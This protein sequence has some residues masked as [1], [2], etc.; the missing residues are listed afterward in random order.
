MRNEAPHCL[1]W[2]AHHQSIGIEH[3]IVYSNDCDDG[4]TEILDRLQSIGL[5]SHIPQPA[6]KGRKSIQWQALK[7]AQSHPKLA[8]ADWATVIDCD[9]FINLRAPFETIQDLISAFPEGSDAI[10]MRWRLFGNNGHISA[11]MLT[12]TQAYTSAAPERINLPLAHFFKSLFRVKAFRQLGIHRPKH[13]KSKPAQW[14]DGDGSILP[15]EF[16]TDDDRIN[17]FGYPGGSALV[18]LNHYSIRSTQNFITKRA[19]GLPNKRSR[20]I[21]LEYWVERN[22]NTEEESSI[23]RLNK[24]SQKHLTTLLADNMLSQLHSDAINWH[25]RSFEHAMQNADL[26]QLF[27]H[28]TLADQSTP[29]QPNLAR[30]HLSRLRSLNSSA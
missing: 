26:V 21:G 17:L 16:A 20:E 14:V 28:L 19:R 15:K 22:F 4:T 8:S 1:E 11:P 5:V 7:H 6:P 2:F 18:Q 25:Q 29:P 24:T 27:W 12:T 30:A 13:R 23:S 10:A 3:F 9:E